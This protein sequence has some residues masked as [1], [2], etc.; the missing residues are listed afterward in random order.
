MTS[1]ARFVSSLFLFA[2]LL[3]PL[4]A[5]NTAPAP[6]SDDKAARADAE[7][8]LAIALRSYSLVD[9]ERDQLKAAN[10]QLAADKAAVE[11]RLAEAQIAIPIA[12]QVVAL[13]EQL[14]QTQAQMAAY[15]EENVQLKSRVASGGAHSMQAAPS[16]APVSTA[17]VPPPTAPAR[18]PA[19]I[20]VIVSGDTLLK[21]SQAYYGTPNRWSDILAANRDVLRDE[22]SLVI[23]RSLIIP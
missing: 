19:R 3:T 17:V 1:T 9:A 4:V 12:A 18:S 11:A 7:M 14:R 20:H 10:T 6:V 21:I 23:G 13:R 2:S 16:P 8:K 5:E 22:K 15:A